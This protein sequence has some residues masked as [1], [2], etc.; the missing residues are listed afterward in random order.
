MQ[1]QDIGKQ[2]CLV[3][4]YIANRRGM[5][6]EVGVETCGVIVSKFQIHVTLKL[7]SAVKY[8]D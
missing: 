7:H 3:R 8:L 1:I 5:A 2:I 6:V 4:Y